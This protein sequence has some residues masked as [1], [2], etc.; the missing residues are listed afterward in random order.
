MLSLDGSE[1]F[2]NSNYASFSVMDDSNGIGRAHGFTFLTLHNSLC[3]VLIVP[4][5]TAMIMLESS[6]K[7]FSNDRGIDNWLKRDTRKV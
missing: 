6:G 4:H 1:E 7:V 2:F 3:L 5:C